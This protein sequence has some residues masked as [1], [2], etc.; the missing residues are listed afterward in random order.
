VGY[1]D[2]ESGVSARI[3]PGQLIYDLLLYFLLRGFS[4]FVL[5][6][7]SRTTSRTLYQPRAAVVVLGGDVDMDMFLELAARIPGHPTGAV[8]LVTQAVESGRQSACANGYY[9]LRDEHGER[10][11]VC[12]RFVRKPPFLK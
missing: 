1:D 8:V 6:C 10:L 5:Y 4:V 3:K 9:R 7:F 2:A 12:Q 11:R